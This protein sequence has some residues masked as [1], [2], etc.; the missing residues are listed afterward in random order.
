MSA[1]LRDSHEVDILTP[2]SIVSVKSGSNSFNSQARDLFLAVTN[3]KVNGL[4]NKIQKLIVVNC[5]AKEIGLL[6]DFNTTQKI[7]NIQRLSRKLIENKISKE[8]DSE[9]ERHFERLIINGL[10][11]Y[12]MPQAFDFKAMSIWIRAF[13]SKALVLK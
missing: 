2:D 6:P 1:M 11:I 12:F 9:M 8:L 3:E 13:I 5:A 7:A 10:R 4:I